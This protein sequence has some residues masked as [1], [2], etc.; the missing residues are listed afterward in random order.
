M[1]TCAGVL[2]TCT[3]ALAICNSKGIFVPENH[4]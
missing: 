4:Y 1:C 2:Y 3:S